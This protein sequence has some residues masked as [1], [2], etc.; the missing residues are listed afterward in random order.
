MGKFIFGTFLV[1][2]LAFYQL[3]G[4][5]DFVPE[6][7]APADPQVARVAAA[8]A[9]EPLVTAASAAAPAELIEETLQDVAGPEILAETPTEAPDD[10]PASADA[11]FEIASETAQPVET[12]E[13]AVQF[14]SLSVSSDGQIAETAGPQTTSAAAEVPET[15]A[16]PAAPV[17]DFREV[18]GS[19]VNLRSGP[20]TGFDRLDTLV[21]GTQ[22]EVIEVN[23]D[24]W[25]R[26]QVLS[27]GQ[28]GWMAAQFLT[29]G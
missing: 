15:P 7:R 1:L 20:G 10:A 4:G 27:T 14:A 26:L 12:A 22:I 29:D 11:S 3:S 5:A 28:I 17:A 23:A 16:T 9:A 18:A 2:G 8:P 19:R 24:G 6:S 25:A 21:L 13:T